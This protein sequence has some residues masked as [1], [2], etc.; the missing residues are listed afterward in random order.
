MFFVFRYG[1]KIY[2]QFVDKTGYFV[3][4]QGLSNDNGC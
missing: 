2:F 3:Y 4:I 1:I